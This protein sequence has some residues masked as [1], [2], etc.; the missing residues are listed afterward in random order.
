MWSHLLDGI[1]TLSKGDIDRVVCA[2]LDVEDLSDGIRS[3]FTMQTKHEN[4]VFPSGEFPKDRFLILKPSNHTRL[5]QNPQNH[6]QKS[7]LIRDMVKF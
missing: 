2:S 5:T 7:S 3:F 6:T 4:I 1:T